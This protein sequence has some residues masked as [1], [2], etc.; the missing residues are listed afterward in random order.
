MRA[1]K[2][3]IAMLIVSVLPSAAG[4]NEEKFANLPNDVVALIGRP[5]AVRNG[6]QRREPL[7]NTLPIYEAYWDHYNAI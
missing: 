4:S 1:G 6:R 2:L 3:A 5:P 7:R